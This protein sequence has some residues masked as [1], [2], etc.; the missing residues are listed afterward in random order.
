MTDNSKYFSVLF[1][2][3][4]SLILF[5]LGYLSISLSLSLSFY[6]TEALNAGSSPLCN[7]AGFHKFLNN[8]NSS[9]FVS[10]KS[11]SEKWV[12][13]RRVEWVVSAEW[14]AAEQSRA[15][16]KEQIAGRVQSYK[17]MA[18]S[19]PWWKLGHTGLEIDMECMEQQ[20]LNL[21]S[22]QQRVCSMCV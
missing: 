9:A 22:T 19:S 10:L 5:Y 11:W 20:L 16:A 14:V 2:S 3:P 6:T 12:W 13:T 21:S 18:C 7:A 1:K 4:F 17:A 8:N 15:G